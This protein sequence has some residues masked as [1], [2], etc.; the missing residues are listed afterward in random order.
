M[1]EMTAKIR[2][3]TKLRGPD[4]RI[5]FGRNIECCLRIIGSTIDSLSLRTD[6]H[7]GVL[8][9]F[10]RGNSE[11]K[12]EWVEAIASDLG[13]TTEQLL[14]DY[15]NPENRTNILRGLFQKKGR[16]VEGE[17]KISTEAPAVKY[18]PKVIESK[19]P[20]VPPSHHTGNGSTPPAQPRT[21]GTQHNG[22]RR[23]GDNDIWNQEDL[24]AK[25]G[26]RVA[27]LQEKWLRTK[28]IHRVREVAAEKQLTLTEILIRAKSTKPVSWIRM[29]ENA[30]I[31]IYGTEVEALAEACGCTLEYLLFGDKPKEDEAEVSKPI[32]HEE[33]ATPNVSEE[34]PTEERLPNGQS[35]PPAI[36]SVI[37]IPVPKI[38]SV[39]LPAPV[40]VVARP[41][42]VDR[43][44]V[45][46][47]F[48]HVPEIKEQTFFRDRF[49][50]DTTEPAAGV[51]VGT[52][53]KQASGQ[54]ELDWATAYFTLTKE[55]TELKLELNK[56][57]SSFRAYPIEIQDVLFQ[58]LT[59][60][61]E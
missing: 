31:R 44:I 21:G 53:L 60:G 3:P 41:P 19:V 52:L 38:V 55:G 42:V 7:V 56:L 1:T 32:I 8:H 43:P 30:N 39:P 29:V 17:T 36:P 34:E 16:I 5:N 57:V 28:V 12:D 35:E 46:E 37:A 22:V 24:V 49:L 51:T 48:E 40:V 4:Y 58:M 11:V 47:V 27:N 33:E 61:E 6:I 9:G 13:I 10:T 59:G 45:P 26:G 54:G 25:I 50:S 18:V 14:W 23:V 15:G 20:V 2:N